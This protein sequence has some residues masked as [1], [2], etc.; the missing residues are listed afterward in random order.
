[1]NSLARGRMMLTMLQVDKIKNTEVTHK[2]CVSLADSS[3]CTNCLMR[4][5]Y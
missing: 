1:M 4:K 2:V 5:T 3:F